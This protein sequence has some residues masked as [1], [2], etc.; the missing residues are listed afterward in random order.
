MSRKLE[1]LAPAGNFAKLKTALQYGADAVYCGLNRFSLRAAADNLTP[2]ELR[3]GVELAH[4]MGKKLYLTANVILHNHEL[5]G[6]DEICRIAVDA[7]ADAMIIS[8]LGAFEIASQYKDKIRLHVSTQA[9][10][11]NYR[12]MNLWHKMG[13]S[14]VVLARELSFEEI[15]EIRKNVSDELE[16]EMFV[17]GAMCIAYSG[18]CLLSSYLTGRDANSG[19]CAQ[20][21]RWNYY[22]TEEQRPG[23]PM[24]ITENEHGT[25]LFNA[26]DICLVEYL[27]E[28]QR[29]G[30]NSLKI[31]GRVKT[32][33]YNAIVTKAY[34]EAIDAFEE[35]GVDYKNDPYYFEELCKVSH[36]DYY[37]GFALGNP[38]EAGQIYGT[39]SYI[40]TYDII[41]VV[42]RV[43]DGT[44]YLEQRN[45]FC[46]GDCVEFVPPEGRFVSH[47]IRMMK[48]E[49]GQEIDCAPHAQMKVMIDAP[50]GSFPAGTI[51]RKE[52]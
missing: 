30:V 25:F 24:Q 36:R 2:E 1:L 28:I 52:V 43:E 48:N 23:Q 22:V 13:A 29:A 11:T 8:D 37:T 44:V 39:S 42:E 50:E 17:H 6:F 20:P 16:I 9:S 47:Q 5:E 10:N 26:K 46:L 12:S 14:R 33:Y 34:R 15:A 38:M 45:R 40:R 31:E 32:G 27:D 51:I 41:G 3:E 49:R 21:C 7:G 4:G 19:A 18:R 35:K